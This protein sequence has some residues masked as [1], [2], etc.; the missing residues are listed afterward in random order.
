MSENEDKILVVEDDMFLRDLLGQ[1]LDEEGVV[2]QYAEDGLSAIDMIKEIHPDL[3][4]LD[5]ILPGIDGFEVLERIK[6]D[7][8]VKDIPVLI[9]SNLG[10]EEDINK[11]KQLGA[12][13]FL[14]KANVNLNKIVNEI[15]KYL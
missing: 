14:V 3:V 10:Q 2:A 4:V 8:E 7:E 13:D 5:I 1:K 12:E 15:N 11:A 6:Q 9:L